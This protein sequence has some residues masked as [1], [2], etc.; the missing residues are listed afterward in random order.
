MKTVTS[1]E[2]EELIISKIKK[3]IDEFVNNSLNF[4]LKNDITPKGT[5]S[6]VLSLLGVMAAN[7]ADKSDAI[8]LKEKIN[9]FLDDV[10]NNFGEEEE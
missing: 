9:L 1:T 10:I 5:F 3:D 8:I 2:A 6:C 4:F 7:L